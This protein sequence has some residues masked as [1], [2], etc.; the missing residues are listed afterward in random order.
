VDEG[1][2]ILRRRRFI[3]GGLLAGGLALLAVGWRL[4]LTPEWTVLTGDQAARQLICRTVYRKSTR[5]AAWCL[6]RLLRDAAP[7]VQVTAMGALAYRPDLQ[8]RFAARLRELTGAGDAEVRAA[9]LELLFQHGGME[10]AQWLTLALA[11]LRDPGFCERH[12]A[13]LAYLVTQCQRG[14]AA[15]IDWLLG[16]LEDPT[17]DDGG[18]LQAVL[19]FPDLLG[20]QRARLAAAY[21]KAGRSGRRFIVAALAAIDGPLQAQ[22]AAGVERF[23]AEAE[24]AQRLDPNFQIEMQ[25]GELCIALG[26]GAGGDH[27]WRRHEYSTVDIGKA[28][29]TF[30]LSRAGPYQVWCRAWFPDKCGNNSLLHLDERW[31]QWRDA[32]NDDRADLLRAWH[33]KR[34]ERE[35]DLAAGRHTLTIT[36]GD[37][38]PLYD[39]LAVLPVGESFNPDQPPPLLGLYEGAVPTAVSLSCEWQCQSRGSTQ[40]L[41]AWVRRNRPDLL[42]GTVALTVPPPFRL[43]SP[44]TVDV[45]FATPSPIASAAF[46]VELPAGCSG[47]EAEVVAT[48]AAAGEADAS[49]TLV[50]GVN[51]DWYTTGPLAPA[52]PRAR[53]LVAKTDLLPG[54]LKDGWQRYPESGYDRYRRLDFEMAYGQQQDRVVFLYTEIE[55]GRAGDYVSLLTLDD[56]GYVFIDGQRLA[57]RQ[58]PDVGEGWL[59]VDKVHLSQGRHR[60]FAWVY[61][62]DVP[63][64][65]GPDAGRHSPNHWVFKWLLRAAL[66][67]PAPQ[68]HSVP[69]APGWFYNNME[70]TAVD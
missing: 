25:E 28:Y 31:L 42:R 15:T 13:I 68:I 69:V 70:Y 46:Q 67:R 34:L 57:G 58:Q 39:K 27:F 12:P 6:E 7:G 35:V 20:P 53:T 40:S 44:A 19:R 63:E 66:H 17:F 55:V 37:D 51:H 54:E 4:T 60:V 26:E 1:I 36:A 11:E 38:G 9:A 29:Y 24:W 49:G 32:G 3:L 59:M 62:A 23:T 30:T 50:L 64:P 10:P 47:G 8:A 21:A 48:F 41:T 56:N 22:A 2:V 33:W 52:D 14:D 61:Q 65:S 16:R 18:A 45:E 43:L 5:R